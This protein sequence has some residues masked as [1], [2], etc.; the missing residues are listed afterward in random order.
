PSTAYSYVLEASNTAGMSAPSSPPATVT[1]PAAP[2]IPTGLDL[3][4]TGTP[5]VTLTWNASSGTLTGYDIEFSADGGLFSRIASN[6]SGTRYTDTTVV[7]GHTYSYAVE[8]NWGGGTLGYCSP[9]QITL[10]PAAP[11]A[12]AASALPRSVSLS[13]TAPFGATSYQILRQGPTDT[14]HVVIGTSGSPNFTDTSVIPEESYSYLIRAV[15]SAGAS[16]ASS[17]VAATTPA[18]PNAPADLTAAVNAGPQ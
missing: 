1:T 2:S 13:W 10:I 9:Q 12:P 4:A 3:S 17:A 11:T 15:N 7:A 8:S 5:A 16:V 18:A 14:S 6:W